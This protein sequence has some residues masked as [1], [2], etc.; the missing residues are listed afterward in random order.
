MATC[1]RCD[2]ER[3]R[4]IA[5]NIKKIIA[6]FVLDIL[7]ATAGT[8]VAVSQL[9]EGLHHLRLAAGLLFPTVLPMTK[10]ILLSNSEL[11]FL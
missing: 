9:L 5:V 11:S 2:T 8:Y 10:L 4:E 7:V 1:R 3:Y 6:P